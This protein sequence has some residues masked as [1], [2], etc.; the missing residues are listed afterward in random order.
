MLAKKTGT[1]TI[2]AKTGS[3]KSAKIKVTVKN[4]S[5]PSAT[6]LRL[7][8]NETDYDFVSRMSAQWEEAYSEDHPELGNV[9]VRVSVVGEDSAGYEAM[10]APQFAADVF[11]VPSDQVAGL[12]QTNTICAMPDAVVNQIKATYG[13]ATA[14]LT[15]YN[16]SY[17]GFPYAANTAL[18][19]Y[20]DKSVFTEEDVKSLN[21]MLAKDGVQGKVIGNDSA[22]FF[23][24]TWFFTGGGELFTGSDMNVCTFDQE[25]VA[26][27]L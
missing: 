17:Y 19:L 24:S 5:D 9:K 25:S 15:S 1:V 12:A 13:E 14:D 4:D 16:G 11:S 26:E 6:K 20:Y 21:A 3:G 18:A 8:C 23:S 2:T 10:S 7:W 22:S 27:V